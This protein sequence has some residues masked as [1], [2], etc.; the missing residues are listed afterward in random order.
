VIAS[1]TSVEDVQEAV[2]DIRPGMRLLPAGGGTKPALSTSS[3][4]DVEQ[5]NLSALSGIL[6][7]D[8]A[9]L[10]ITALAG[11]PV[12]EIETALAEHGQH[13]PFDPPMVAAGATLGGVVAAGASGPGAW[14]HGSVRDFVI[15][16]RFVDGTGRVIAGGGKVVKNAAGFDL[17]KLM[18]G[19]AGR[20]GVI[21]QLSFKVFPRP[22]AT[23]TL[24]FSFA[25]IEQA[26]SAAVAIARGP[27]ELDSL[28]ILPGGRLLARVGGR[29]EILE[30]RADRLNRTLDAPVT[31]H[32][33][34][35]EL[36]LWSDATEFTWVPADSVLVRVA[37]SIRQVLALNA[38][39][40]TVAGVHVRYSIGGTVAWLSWPT[41]APL[42]DLDK[43]LN[44]LGLPAMV[45]IG[46]ADSTFLGPKTGGAFGE[47]I[48]QALDPDSRFLEV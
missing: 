24:E 13:L 44:K 20:L 32:T 1:A 15:G 6:E 5:L 7:Y 9:E 38:A 36:A 35:S 42:A 11:T 29:T 26:V 2:R 40:G 45:L 34:A 39:L 46:P 18:V 8:P 16:I 12:R 25:T 23:T 21:I 30:A 3:H 4:D 43:I 17:P 31:S 22:I 19:S 10:T 14:R 37:L 41:D 27:V 47:R 48:I 33:G 28:E